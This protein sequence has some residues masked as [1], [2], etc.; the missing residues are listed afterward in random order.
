MFSIRNGFLLKTKKSSYTA[1][2]GTYP[3][4]AL[5][6]LGAQCVWGLITSAVALSYQKPHLLSAHSLH[7]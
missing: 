1:L 4:E 5:S 3:C 6:N 2:H 7:I